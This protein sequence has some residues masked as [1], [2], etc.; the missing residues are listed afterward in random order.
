MT[1]SARRL[2]QDP[3]AL[4]DLL[5]T[6]QVRRAPAL[7]PAQIRPLSTGI[8]ALDAALGGGLARGQ[9]HEIVAPA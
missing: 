1:L 8:P 5:R 6:G 4:E 9:L 3:R 2:V 7:A